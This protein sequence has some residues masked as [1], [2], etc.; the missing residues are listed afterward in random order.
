MSSKKAPPPQHEIEA[1]RERLGAYRMERGLSFEK[2]AY[3]IGPTHISGPTVKRFIEGAIVIPQ[4]MT[5]FA[6]RRYMAAQGL[7]AA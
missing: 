1:L 4:P 3:E 7:L 2:M 5:L 6:L